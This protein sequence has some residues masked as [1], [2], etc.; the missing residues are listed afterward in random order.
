MTVALCDSDR[1][2]LA[3]SLSF[4]AAPTKFVNIS[5]KMSL[6]LPRLAVKRP[7]SAIKA[8]VDNAETISRCNAFVAKHKKK[9]Q[10]GFLN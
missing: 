9:V 7:K 1:I 8:S 5:L 10:F 4:L 6:G 2:R 3:N